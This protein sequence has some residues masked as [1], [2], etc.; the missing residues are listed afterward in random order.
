ME[1]A[2]SAVTDA[3]RSRMAAVTAEVGAHVVLLAAQQVAPHPFHVTA[4]SVLLS[5]TGDVRLLPLAPAT[6]VEVELELRQLLAGLLTLAPAAPPAFK[7]AA[8][9]GAGGGLD[10]LEAELHAALIPINHAAA[11]R[12]LARLFRETRRASGAVGASLEQT[13][14][15]AAEVRSIPA[16]GAALTTAVARAVREPSQAERTPVNT[17]HAES[18]PGDLDIDVDVV[19]ESEPVQSSAEVVNRADTPSAAMPV[20]DVT[21]AAARAGEPGLMDGPPPPPSNPRVEMGAVEVVLGCVDHQQDAAR[22]DVGEL[23][24]SFL[25]HTRSEERMTED[26]RRMLGVERAP[27]RGAYFVNRVARPGTDSRR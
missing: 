17:P 18:A 16:A 9:R 13:P 20:R 3:G 11:R 7:T 1:I 19:D 24:A 12:A 6:S 23:L 22:S 10:A 2:L 25:A 4:E 5:D 27:A 14:V 21:P 26:L 8:E 15:G